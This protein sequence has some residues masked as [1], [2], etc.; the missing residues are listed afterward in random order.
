M[1]ASA[2]AGELSFVTEPFQ[3]FSYEESPGTHVAAGPMADVVQAVCQRIGKTCRMAV[4]PWR[5]AYAMAANGEVDG[6]FSIIRIPERE[7]DF[8]VSAMVAESAYGFFAAAT[9]AFAYRRPEDLR[10]HIIAVYGPSGTSI[11]LDELVAATNQP[12][13]VV[14]DI[15]NPTVLKKLAAGRYGEGDKVI[16]AMNREVGSYLTANEKIAGI[17]YVGDFRKISYGIGLS[18]KKV[19][20]EQFAEFNN[21]LKTLIREGKVK[22]I[23]DKYGLKPAR[24]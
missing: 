4:L 14:L 3:P 16:A 23:L 1:A 6:L 2:C 19:T 11:A 22:A 9:S 21:A 15:S 12:V 18:R 17:K 13:R 7:K 5:R 20:P 10:D 8:Y 24:D